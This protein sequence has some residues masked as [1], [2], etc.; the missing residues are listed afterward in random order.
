MNEFKLFSRSFPRYLPNSS[1]TGLRVGLFATSH[2]TTLFH[3]DK[4]YAWSLASISNFFSVTKL[5]SI[6]LVICFQSSCTFNLGKFLSLSNP[7]LK[8]VHLFMSLFFFSLPSHQN[9]QTNKCNK[10]KKEREETKDEIIKTEEDEKESNVPIEIQDDEKKQIRFR[11]WV[12]GQSV[13]YEGH[14]IAPLKN[15]KKKKNKVWFRDWKT[16]QMAIRNTPSAQQNK[17][18]LRKEIQFIYPRAIKAIEV[19]GGW[20]EVAK[21]MGLK[22]HRL[23]PFYIPYMSKEEQYEFIQSEIDK[24]KALRKTITIDQIQQ[25][26]VIK[27]KE[28]PKPVVLCKTHQNNPKF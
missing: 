1:A 6:F 20:I 5:L 10:K 14:V 13:I 27:R 24:R 25:W 8:Q 18:P 12:P 15:P 16:L 4:R 26:Q 22:P 11:K 23:P 9:K 17:M 28:K 2:N 21:R 19:H 7:S 3:Y